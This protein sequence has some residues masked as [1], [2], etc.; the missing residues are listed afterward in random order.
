MT[1]ETIAQ[2]AMLGIKKAGE[3]KLNIRTIENPIPPGTYS[4]AVF[5]KLFPEQYAALTVAGMPHE[6]HSLI[7]ITA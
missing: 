5:K 3:S 2:L 7:I 4:T 1:A 6:V